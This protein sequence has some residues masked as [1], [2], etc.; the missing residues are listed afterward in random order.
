MINAEKIIFGEQNYYTIYGDGVDFQI[1][2]LCQG[3]KC[4]YKHEKVTI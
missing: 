3:R 2:E 4:I 1:L